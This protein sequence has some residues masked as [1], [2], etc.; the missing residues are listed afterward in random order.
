MRTSLLQMRLWLALCTIGLWSNSHPVVAQ[1]TVTG[2]VIK[3]SV[4][5]AGQRQES[6]QFSRP[7]GRI[8]SRIE[9]RL[10]SR[11]RQRIDRYYDPRQVD[12]PTQVSI[13]QDQARTAR[14]LQSR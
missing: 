4:G 11:L 8:G 10:P 2:D 3:S 14:T 6:E 9:N 13:A 5:K 12:A 7:L 1:S